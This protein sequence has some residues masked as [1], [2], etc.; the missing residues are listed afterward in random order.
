MPDIWLSRKES[1]KRSTPCP[2]TAS[3][4]SSSVNLIFVPGIK[5]RSEAFRSSPPAGGNTVRV[6]LEKEKN[7]DRDHLLALLLWL[8]DG[9][10]FPS[11]CNHHRPIRNH[12]MDGEEGRALGRQGYGGGSGFRCRFITERCMRCKVSHTS[13]SLQATHRAAA[14]R[15]GSKQRRE[16]WYDADGLCLFT[17]AMVAT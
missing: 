5:Q 14:K 3:C 16:M 9:A 13:G 15:C 11:L 12:Y 1:I 8:V 4:L 2:R 6:R 17:Q 10:R 7:G